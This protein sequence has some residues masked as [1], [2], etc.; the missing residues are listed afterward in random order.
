[1]VRKRFLE[2]GLL[3]FLLLFGSQIGAHP[4][5]PALLQL[6]QVE[7]GGSYR[8]VW[9]RYAV[10]SGAPLQP[11]F[12][13]HC[14]ES[15]SPNWQRDDLSAVTGVW[16]IECGETGLRGELLSVSGVE[17]SLIN[18]IV[19]VIPSSGEEFQ[20]LLSA[21]Q[22][23][24]EIPKAGEES[25][26]LDHMGRYFSIGAG[27][28]IIGADHI[29]FLLGLVIL[30]SGWRR[31]LWTITAFTLGHSLT[32]GLVATGL[33]TLPS[34]F[35]EFLIALTLLILAREICFG[36]SSQ[37]DS[38]SWIRR[39]PAWMAAGFGLVHGCGFAGA[40]LQLGLP[41]SAVLPALFA[42]NLGIEF[43]Q[44]G[45]VLVVLALMRFVGR[46][47]LEH[48]RHAIQIATAY[49]MGGLA[50]FWCLDR[51]IAVWPMF[52]GV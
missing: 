13:D 29:L 25:S 33:V 1:M 18:V 52:A 36:S 38:A 26:L 43:A 35:M 22:P 16:S 47:V 50:A 28:F 10:Q 44:V 8:V 31:L 19:R 7:G 39:H 3:A 24:I 14:V 6:E 49:G 2:C 41:S 32:L 46:W 5:A 45:M 4:L 40:L 21:E 9:R 48:R 12:P 17:R 11:V 30:V 27:H 37:A 20:A 51:A 34:M 42:F 15:G 23:S